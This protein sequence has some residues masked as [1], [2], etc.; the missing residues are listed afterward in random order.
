M[1]AFTVGLVGAFLLVAVG[2]YALATQK[3]MIKLILGVEIMTNG[4][5]LALIS[6]AISKPVGIDPVI[7]SLAILAIGI[8]GCV[9]AVGL[10]ITVQAYRHYK[11]LDVRELKRL[12]Y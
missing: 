3:N 11:T 5:I 9:A 1:E 7:P 12:R 2:L 6:F 8:G 10:A 4:A